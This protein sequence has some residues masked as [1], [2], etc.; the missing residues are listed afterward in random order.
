MPWRTT[1]LETLSVA[2][3]ERFGVQCFWS[4]PGVRDLAPI[5][6]AKIVAR[7]IQKYG[8]M[9]GLRMAA[10]IEAELRALGEKPWR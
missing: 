6:R 7:Q 3:I 10:E 2:A 9:Q 5:P 8:G 1:H 4:I